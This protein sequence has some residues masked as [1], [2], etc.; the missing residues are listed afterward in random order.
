M[1]AMRGAGG[2][3]RFAG[4]KL[5]IGSLEGTIMR[6]MALFAIGVSFAA[7]AQAASWTNFAECGDSHHLHI[8]SYDPASVSARRGNVAVRVNVD[9]SRDPASRAHNGRMIWSLNCAARTYFE[10][11]RVDY[12]ANRSVV[13][14]YR[15]PSQTMTIIA[16]SVADKLARK[17]CA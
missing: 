11:S 7:A 14:N 1:T 10:K 2:R 16:D 4:Y 6:R 17:V 12:R 5:I 8:Y 3:A 9:Y 15:A 13:A